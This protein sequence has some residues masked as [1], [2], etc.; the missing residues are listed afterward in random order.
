MCWNSKVSL[1]TF[2]FSTTPLV[3]CLYFKL[4]NLQNYLIYQ[5]FFSMQLLE[6]FLWTNLNNKMWNR[7]FSMVGFTLIVLLAAFSIY[8]NKHKY[9]AYVLGLYLLFVVYILSNIPIDFNTTVAPNKHLSWNWLK[10]PLP[11]IVIWTLFFMYS[12]V[13]SIYLGNYTHLPVM[14]FTAFIYLFTFYSYYDSNTFGTMWCWIANANAI[15]FYYLLF[16][17]LF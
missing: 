11:I 17:L 10:L 12:S 8:G 7:I 15:Y 3:L 9:S 14:I 2:I 5:T 1:Q 16:N 4:I 13:F 6:Y